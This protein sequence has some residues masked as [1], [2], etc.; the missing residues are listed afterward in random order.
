MVLYKMYCSFV[1]TFPVV[2]NQVWT[3]QKGLLVLLTKLLSWK[4]IPA[5]CR[6]T[7]LSLVS[8]DGS[9]A[10]PMEDRGLLGS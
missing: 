3:L 6:A 10:L 2:L 5:S 9:L 1:N 4:P 8:L 7:S